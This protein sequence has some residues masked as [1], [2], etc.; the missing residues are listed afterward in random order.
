MSTRSL[1]QFAAS[2]EELLPAAA[3]DAPSIRIDRVP[4]RFLV[5]PR[6]WTAIWFTDV[7]AN[8]QCLQIVDDG[9]AV[10]ALVGNDFLDYCDGVVRDGAD[11]LE[12]LGP[13]SPPTCTVVG[14]VSVCPSPSAAL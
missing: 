10:L 9:T 14:R 7:G 3:A 6:L 1:K 4:F 2:A 11:R 5:R 8:L 12:L 13:S